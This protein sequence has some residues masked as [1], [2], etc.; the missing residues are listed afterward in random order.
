MITSG[1]H[2]FANED[3]EAHYWLGF[4]RDGTPDEKVAARA[5]LAP[6]FERR[7][8]RGEAIELLEANGRQ[9][10][11]DAELFAHLASLYRRVGRDADADAALAEVVTLSTLPRVAPA[12]SAP[13]GGGEPGAAPPERAVTV[14][15]PAL[16]GRRACPACGYRNGPVRRSCKSCRLPLRVPARDATA[17][18]APRAVP[19]P[20]GRAQQKTTPVQNGAAGRPANRRPVDGIA[21]MRYVPPAAR[22]R[23]PVARPPTPAAGAGT[24]IVMGLFLIGSVG[25]AT[26]WLLVTFA[27]GGR[28]ASV[29]A[30]SRPADV[31]Q[32]S[33]Q[34]TTQTQP[35]GPAASAPVFEPAS[36]LSRTAAD[37]TTRSGAPAAAPVTLSLAG[38]GGLQPYL[39][40]VAPKMLAAGTTTQR[41]S[42]LANRIARDPSLVLNAAWK[43]EMA[44]ALAEMKA[45]G[46]QLQAQRAAPQEA[47]ELNATLAAL[48]ADLVYVADEMQ[49]GIDGL[50]PVRLGN[51]LSRTG[52]MNGRIPVL[53]GQIERLTSQ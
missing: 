25:L 5:K 45:V 12:R 37:S 41:I 53:T 34:A 36:G 1:G 18:S 3:A 31:A 23:G 38:P 7:G 48:G 39:A 29:A 16:D 40:D 32:S 49:A 33:Q 28:P 30:A 20:R 21:A 51:A 11:R 9:G 17:H 52:E 27:G 46:S 8:M 44:A 4:L 22:R 42:D 47:Q 15:Q 35:A 2:H 43:G 26:Y 13:I 10:V 19:A 24:T 14:V 50:N 6:I